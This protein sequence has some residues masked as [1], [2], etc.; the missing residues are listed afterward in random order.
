MYPN[1]CWASFIPLPGF[2]AFLISC[3]N[4]SLHLWQTFLHAH[5]QYCWGS[6]SNPRKEQVW[7]LSSSYCTKAERLVILFPDTSMHSFTSLA[8]WE[9]EGRTSISRT[10]REWRSGLKIFK[11]IQSSNSQSSSQPKLIV[12]HTKML[13]M[14][15]VGSTEADLLPVSS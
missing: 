10:G 2:V 14:V 11:I 13:I 4:S 3:S 9:S 1:I 15:R 6:L 8:A 12:L 5:C 7:L